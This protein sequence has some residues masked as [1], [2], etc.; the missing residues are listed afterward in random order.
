M[1]EQL[2]SLSSSGVGGFVHS[3]VCLSIFMFIYI[4]NNPFVS[5]IPVILFSSSSRVCQCG[6]V[7]F[8]FTLSALVSVAPTMLW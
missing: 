2:H 5:I 1:S 3:F 8:S 4:V 7:K 6:K